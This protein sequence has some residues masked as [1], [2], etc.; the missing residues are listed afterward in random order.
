VTENN[1]AT[2]PRGRQVF[3]GVPFQVN[4]IVQLSGKKNLEWGRTEYPEA[5]KDIKLGKTVRQFHLLHGAGGVYDGDGTIIAKL[6][7]H[8]ADRSEQAIEIKT[9]EHVR[10][11]WGDP[12]QAVTG[13]N[14]E[15]AWK[16]SNPA[17][18]KYGG[19]KPGSLRIYKTTF[20]N[21]QP[22]VSV[23]SIDY[24]ST[25]RNSASFLMGLTIE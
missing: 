9:G 13:K 6:V 25:M 15:L 18:Q 20:A 17:I 10:D 19:A 5:V 21:P 12:T 7:L 11:W 16:G 23:T 24:I 1:L 4:G 2:F 8:Y 14:S 3:S 22:D